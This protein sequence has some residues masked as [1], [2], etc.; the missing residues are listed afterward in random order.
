[1]EAVGALSV[2]LAGDPARCAPYLERAAAFDVDD[3]GELQLGDAAVFE[4]RDG[5]R[6]VG[7]FALEVSTDSRGH[8]VRVLAAG[9]EPG[10][11]LTGEMVRFVEREA[12][13][14][15]G[16][17]AIGCETRRRG[18]VKRLQAEGFK[19]AGFIL[20]KDL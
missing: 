15:I 8:L 14:R 13:D 1:M 5:D 4:L 12:R 11:D 2:Q 6:L 18:L 16:A 7:A 3:A 17:R 9:G 10:H 20:R 19:V